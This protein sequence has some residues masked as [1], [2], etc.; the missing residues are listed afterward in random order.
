MERRRGRNAMLRVA[1]DDDASTELALDLDAIC[2]EGARRMLAAALEAEADAYTAALIDEVDSDGHRLVVRNGHARPR[3]VA[4][5][6]RPT[7]DTPTSAG[8]ETS[9]TYR[10][11]RGSCSWRR[12]STSAHVSPSDG[13]SPGTCAPSCAPTPSPPRSAGED[14]GPWTPRSSTPTTAVSTP[15]PRCGVSVLGRT[16]LNRWAQSVTA[17]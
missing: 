8:S 16:S 4:T 12:C 7:A 15:R 6:A 2:R 9:P 17:S 13:P 3:V 1:V 10:P 14:E 11:T 5:G